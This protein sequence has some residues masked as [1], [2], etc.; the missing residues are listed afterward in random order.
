VTLP[1]PDHQWTFVALLALW[2]LGTLIWPTGA[3]ALPVG[4]AW[5]PDTPINEPGFVYLAAPRIDYD[6]QTGALRLAAAAFG[7]SGFDAFGYEWADSLWSRTWATG[8]GTL[9]LWPVLSPPGTYHL[10]WSGGDDA[11]YGYLYMAELENG[12]L[13]IDTVAATAEAMTEYAA[14]VTPKRRWAAVSDR[15][16]DKTLRVLYSD[17]LGIWREMSSVGQG[18]YGVAI[19]A[20]DDTSALVVWSGLNEGIKWGRIAGDLWAP[21]GAPIPG[22]LANRV[23]MRPDPRGGYW[24]AW[25]TLSDYVNIAQFT[26]AGPG[27]IDTLRCN[28]ANQSASHSTDS[29]DPSR[30]DAPRPVVAWGWQNDDG[31]LGVCICFP[32]TLGYAM[33]EEMPNAAGGVL[34]SLAVDRNGDTWLAWWHYGYTSH[35]MHTYVTATAVNPSASRSGLECSLA[36]ELS[37]LAPKSW[38]A[39]LRSPAGEDDYAEVARVQAGADL[40]MSWTD[41]S[42]PTWPL[43]YVIRRESVD[44]RYEWLSE[45]VLCDAA[46]SVQVS[47]ASAVAESDRVT[48]RWQGVGAGALDAMVERRGESTGWQ[49]LGPALADGP[50]RLVY[51]DQSILPGGRYGYRLAYLEHGVQRFTAE[52]WV[53]VPNAF[54]LALEG[55]R[56]NPATSDAVIS[57]TLPARGTVRLEVVDIAGRRVFTNDAG[58]LGPGRHSFPLNTQPAL[59]PGVYVIRLVFGARVLQTRGVVMR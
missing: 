59:A 3:A 51:Q 47:L 27:P 10:I 36:W 50:D 56:P 38:W 54:E 26:E 57:F 34:P 16:P 52:S 29:P 49:Q 25:G 7:Y 9:A 6:A 14:A 11:S 5:T 32:T 24:A 17:T 4:R 30:D 1:K 39:V 43:H 22:L 8:N 42:A 13:V 19:G 20:L 44:K 21:G 46:V 18:D 48:L 33:G 53:E 23:R 35:W 2:A 55:F 37:E 40:S 31:Q 12:A 28:Y 45:P 58:D 41:P 15:T